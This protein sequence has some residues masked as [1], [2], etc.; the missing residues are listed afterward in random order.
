MTYKSLE[1]LTFIF[2]IHNHF[3]FDPEKLGILKVSIDEMANGV[4]YGDYALGIVY[5]G[6]KYDEVDHSSLGGSFAVY[7]ES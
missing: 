3:E 2:H 7:F 6:E 5:E 1:N 4:D